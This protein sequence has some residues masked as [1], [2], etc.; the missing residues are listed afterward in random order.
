M[1]RGDRVRQLRPDN[2]GPHY[3]GPTGVIALTVTRAQ[4][5][6]TVR[7]TRESVSLGIGCLRTP[8]EAIEDSRTMV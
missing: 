6:S 3:P 1:R 2:S 7:G 4:D 5:P 8:D